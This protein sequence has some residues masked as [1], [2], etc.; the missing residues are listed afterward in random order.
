MNDNPTSEAKERKKPGRKAETPAQRLER[1]E[2]EMHSAR[3]AVAEA[4]Q[5]KLAT[6]GSAVMIEAEN[7]PAFMDQ[8]RRIL[9]E[10]V[11]SKTGKASVASLLAAGSPAASPIASP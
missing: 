7:N 6:I 11:T 3:R 8:L 4:E 2:R 5:Q 1:L 10:R 9:A